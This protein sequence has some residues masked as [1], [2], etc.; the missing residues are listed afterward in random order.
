MAE[1]ESVEHDEEIEEKKKEA[2]EANEDREVLSGI[3]SKEQEEAASANAHKVEELAEAKAKKKLDAAA[4][5]AHKREK[6]AEERIK[7]LEQELAAKTPKPTSTTTT[8]KADKPAA[9]QRETTVSAEGVRGS[10]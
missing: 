10:R 6:A 5:E 4:K 8:S 9:P 7:K 1:A 3:E 2:V